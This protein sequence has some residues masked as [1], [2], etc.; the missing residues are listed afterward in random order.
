MKLLRYGPAGAERP[1]ILDRDGQL[2]D[3]SAHVDDLAG[4]AL[5]PASLAAL[6]A[7]DTQSLPL[8]EGAPRIGA[9]VGGVGKF[10]VSVR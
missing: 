2:R 10:M 7:L 9:C 1:A 6:S 5:S 8:V 3:L 4:S